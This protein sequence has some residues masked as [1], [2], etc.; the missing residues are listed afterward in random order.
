MFNINKNYIQIYYESFL[1]ISTISC[2]NKIFHCV[3]N[4][5]Q[6]IY[7]TH[8]GSIVGMNLITF[9]IY[10]SLCLTSINNRVIIKSGTFSSLVSFHV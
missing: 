1:N 3:K 9:K 2:S 6:K 10:Y 8:Y 4:Q 5:Y 7:T